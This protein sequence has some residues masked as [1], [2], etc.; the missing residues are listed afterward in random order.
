MGVE[1][2]W[3]PW[4]K[5]LRSDFRSVAHE[6]EMEE[7]QDHKAHSPAP[8]Q[9]REHCNP[10]VEDVVKVSDLTRIWVTPWYTDKAIRAVE[11]VGVRAGHPRAGIAPARPSLVAEARDCWDA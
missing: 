10:R 9:V 2:D 5:A 4:G 11:V 8:N 1:H 7:C 3:A 6:V